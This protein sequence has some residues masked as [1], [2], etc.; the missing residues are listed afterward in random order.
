MFYSQK[1]CKNQ[2]DSASANVNNSAKMSLAF[3]S[4]MG[5]IPRKIDNRL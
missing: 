4:K 1:M 3:N 5:E 2:Q